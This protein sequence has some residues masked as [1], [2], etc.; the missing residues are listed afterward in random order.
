MKPRP[1]SHA[2]A[3]RRRAGLLALAV[4]ALASPVRADTTLG[5]RLSGAECKADTSLWQFDRSHMRV[6][7][8]V[9][10][11]PSHTIYDHAEKLSYVLFPEKRTFFQSEMD[12][13]AAEFTGD[14]LTSMEKYSRR[15]HGAAGWSG[16]ADCF[17]DP[18]DLLP[19]EMLACDGTD[20]LFDGKRLRDGGRRR[21]D[22]DVGEATVDGIV[23][24]RREHRRDG[25]LL[26]TD[27]S[28]SLAALR[29]PAEENRWVERIERHLLGAARLMAPQMQ[30]QIER[31]KQRLLLV[32]RICY[33][34]SGRESGRAVLRVD[35]AKIPA[36]RFEIPNGYARVDPM[37]GTP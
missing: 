31:L 12:L 30:T 27:C 5:Y 28:T 37:R 20:P 8:D 25:K 24:T 19:G 4:A 22:R 16:T 18:T 32:Q 21:E 11:S 15:K 2:H 10:G 34:S 26:R 36:D 17:L 14:V 6:E 13:D 9:L 1:A 3:T 29:L 35:H 23:C 7:N 33:A